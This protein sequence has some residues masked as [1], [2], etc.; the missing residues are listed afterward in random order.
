MEN[1]EQY[2]E[3]ILSKEEWS[4]KE[5]KDELYRIDCKMYTNLGIDSTKA[6]RKEVK[7]LSRVIYK[8]IQKIDPQEGT[9]LL[10]AIDK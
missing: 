6:D 8:A 9:Q 7:R 10:Q 5:K 1:V 3:E 2:V 4:D